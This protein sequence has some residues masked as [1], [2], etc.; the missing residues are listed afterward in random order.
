MT[1]SDEDFLDFWVEVETQIEEIK[2]NSRLVALDT[3]ILEVLKEI[4][5]ITAG[6]YDSIVIDEYLYNKIDVIIKRIS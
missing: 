6:A 2:D 3:E 4:H 5:S 1:A